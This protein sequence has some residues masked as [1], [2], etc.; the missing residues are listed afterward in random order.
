MRRFREAIEVFLI[1]VCL[2]YIFG[3][4]LLMLLGVFQ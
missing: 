2:S 3:L 1:V 4:P